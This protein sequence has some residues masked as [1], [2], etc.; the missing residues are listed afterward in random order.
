[1]HGVLSLYTADPDHFRSE[2]EM[3]LLLSV[4]EQIGGVIENAHLREQAER[5]MV[6][7]ERNRLARALHDSVTQ[8]L[9]SVPLFAEA[10]RNL[11]EAEAYERASHY[12]DD[13]LQTGQQA[14][15]EMRLLVH[16]L[17]P[18][19]LEQ[20]GLVRA[21]QH[22]LNA[23]EGRAGIRHQ[24]FVEENLSLSAELEEALYH[25]SQEALNNSIKHAFASEVT[26]HLNESDDE[27]VVL[28]VCDNG[29]GF[30]AETAVTSGGLGLISIRE[31]VSLLGGTVTFQSTPQAGTIV[32]VQI[33]K[34]VKH[35]T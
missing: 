32:S 4:G 12:F 31:R 34:S 14:L 27:Q 9:Y 13:V 2:G 16:N 5:L 3:D 29:Q 21:L 18:S 15:K 6:A 17:R 22:R 28:K 35:K 25:I 7:D 26:V 11:S 20:D 1:M 33:P 24:L 30:D 8:S 10:G 23:V 19:A